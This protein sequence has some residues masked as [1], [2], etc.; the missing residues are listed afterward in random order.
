MSEF[1][2]FIG[3]LVLT[4]SI[5]GV[6]CICAELFKRWLNNDWCRHD[7]GMWQSATSIAEGSFMYKQHRFCKK[8]NKAEKRIL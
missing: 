4:S 2:F 3:S 7:W 5:A 8:C 1:W 6:W